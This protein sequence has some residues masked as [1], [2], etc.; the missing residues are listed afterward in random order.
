[1]SGR[2]IR[3]LLLA[4]WLLEQVKGD[5]EPSCF[6]NVDD[7]G[8]P[9]LQR[10]CHT[11]TVKSRERSARSFRNQLRVFATSVK[12]YIDNVGKVSEADKEALREK[13]ESTPEL[14]LCTMSD[15]DED[16][17]SE[18]Q[19][20]FDWIFQRGR[21][22]PVAR[23]RARSPKL[24]SPAEAR[25]NAKVNGITGKLSQVS[26][27]P[28]PFSCILTCTLQEFRHV[29][30]ASVGGMQRA[31][32]DGLEEKCQEGANAVRIFDIHGT[33]NSKGFGQA[34]EA[35]LETS[36]AFAASMHWATYR[37]SGFLSKTTIISARQLTGNG[38]IASHGCLAEKP[39]R[40]TDL[41]YDKEHCD[42]M[43]Q[44]VRE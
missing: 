9:E 4:Q 42:L 15:D 17:D 43:G 35:A 34:A 22:I 36:D 24:R 14:G 3:P 29:I 31:F 18:D 5:G 2:F 12:S 40:G 7:A 23:T 13:W 37:A 44:D 28:P 21:L 33:S 30:A 20:D 1:M 39:Q 8:V 6:T 16:Q 27:S 41:A 25:G 38:S 10:W 26:R 19:D 32:K 11:L